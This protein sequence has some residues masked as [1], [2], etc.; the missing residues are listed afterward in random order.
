[1]IIRAVA[2]DPYDHA[3]FEI[4]EPLQ[5]ASHEVSS[6]VVDTVAISITSNDKFMT[7]DATGYFSAKQ[8]RRIA[9]ACIKAAKNL[10]Q[11]TK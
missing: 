1:M 3:N 2:G 5:Q 8:L 10:E 7:V 4:G 6:D 9:A 11:K